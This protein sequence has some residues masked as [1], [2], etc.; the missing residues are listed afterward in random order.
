MTGL[1]K[2]SLENKEKI[3]IMYLDRKG[4]LTQRYVTV[5]KINQTHVVCYCHY[6]KQRRMFRL[7]NILAA[8][9]FRSRDK[10]L[11]VEA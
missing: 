4:E 7:K 2:R 5:V 1:L 3:Q 10:D 11:F 8:S 9:P 6:K